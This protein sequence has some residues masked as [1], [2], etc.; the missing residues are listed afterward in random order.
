MFLL[1]GTNLAV[2]PNLGK[3]HPFSCARERLRQSVTADLLKRGDPDAVELQSVAVTASPIG[4]QVPRSTTPCKREYIFGLGRHLMEPS[5]CAAV[6]RPQ[7]ADRNTALPR[8]NKLIVRA[9][10][11]AR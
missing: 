11:R 10:E 6:T 3:A 2:R 8:P 9:P 1:A 7:F 5:Q 4:V